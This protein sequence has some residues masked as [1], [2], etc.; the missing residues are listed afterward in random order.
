MGISTRRAINARIRFLFQVAAALKITD[1]QKEKAKI[2]KVS[3]PE[4]QQ[5]MNELINFPIAGDEKEN[6]Y[7]GIISR[8]DLRP[9]QE[10]MHCTKNAFL[11]RGVFLKIK[12]TSKVCSG[13]ENQEFCYR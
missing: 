3:S 9:V 6:S 4:N 11:G 10:I 8:T 2:Y 1:L 5:M 7:N 12:S 13:S